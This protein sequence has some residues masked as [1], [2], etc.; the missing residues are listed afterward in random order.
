MRFLLLLLMP[1]LMAFPV[2]A[3]Q[4]ALSIGV[5]DIQDLMTESKAAKDITKQLTGYRDDILEEL[6]AKEKELIA[7]EK[8]LIEERK[9]L[10]KEEFSKKVQAFEKDKMQLQKMSNDYNRSIN[11]ASLQAE[12]DLM[13]EIVDITSQIAADR[14]Y[15]LVISKRNVVV[16]SVALDIT[17]DV[18]ALLNKNTPK[19]KVTFKK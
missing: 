14:D 4:E 11:E 18:M 1:F 5:V 16:G 15:S 2:A 6:S 13:K 8:V 19:I 17:K 7:L 10:S 3:Q 12:Q 9:D